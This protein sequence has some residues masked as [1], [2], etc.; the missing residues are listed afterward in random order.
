MLAGC[1]RLC[2]DARAS[3]KRKVAGPTRGEV[4]RRDGLILAPRVRGDLFACGEV[5]E[6]AGKLGGRSW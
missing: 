4:Q 3:E 5:I 2:L 1:L 6:G